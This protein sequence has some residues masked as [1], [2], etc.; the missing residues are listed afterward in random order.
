MTGV[1]YN[2]AMLNIQPNSVS[3]V[4]LGIMQ[5]GGLPHMGCRCR[6]CSQAYEDPHKGE[7]VAC[8]GIVDRRTEPAKM[9]L[10]DATPDIKYQLELLGEYIGPHPKQARRLRQPDGI[11]LTHAHMGHIAGL[12]Q[13]GQAACW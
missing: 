11:F 9:W 8:L 7:Y 4:V 10:V 12:S 1:G 6:R 13:F 3:V 2:P 5:D